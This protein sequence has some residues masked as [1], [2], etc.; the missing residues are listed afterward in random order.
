M[1]RL[2]GMDQRLSTCDQQNRNLNELVM[3]LQKDMRVRIQAK[4]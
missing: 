1:R 2:D 3:K 4:I